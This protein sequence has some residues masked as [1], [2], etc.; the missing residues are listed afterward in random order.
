MSL[1]P[2]R[3]AFVLPRN[4][5]SLVRKR[6]YD[7]SGLPFQYLPVVLVREREFAGLRVR[8]LSCCPILSEKA[9]SKIEESVQHLK[10]EDKTGTEDG[11]VP[12]RIQIPS[13]AV[14]VKD[15]AETS[16]S[17]VVKKSVWVRIVDECKHYYSGFKLLFLDV[18]VSS[19]IVW[20]I[21]NGQTLS[22]RESKQLIRTTSDLF[23]LVPFSVFIIVPFMELLLPVALKLFPGMLPSTFTT[24][25][26][27][28]AKMKRSLVAKLEYAKFLQKTL[29]EM[30][31]EDNQDRS[32]KSARDFVTF[33]KKMKSQGDGVVDN[34]EILK[35]SKLFED[36][37]T[38]DNMTRSQLAAICRLL[39]LTPI[40][41]TNFLRLQLEMRLRHLLTDDKVISKEGLENLTIQE[42]QQACKERGM[43]AL[44][45]SAET[46]R[47]QLQ[48]WLDLS[49]NAQVPPSLLLLSRTL[50][51]P[52]SLEPQAKIAA[53]ISA[54]PESAISATSA[55]IGER[56]G[57][58]R[59]VDRF[60][61]I[62]E[63]QRKID[64]EEAEKVKAE[65]AAKKAAKIKLKLP[66]VEEL[67]DLLHQ[68]PIEKE[69]LDAAPILLDRAI[70][71]RDEKSLDPSDLG[72]LKTAIQNLSKSK[73]ESREIKTL[74]KELVDYEEDLKDLDVLKVSKK[75]ASSLNESKGAKRLFQKVNQMLG[76]VDTLV[77]SLEQKE[78]EITE[79]KAMEGR[80]EEELSRDDEN[81]VTVQELI[82]AV[83]K[84]QRS[85]DS[86]KLEQIS[87]VLSAMDVDSDGMIKVDH[88]QKV[89]ELL[90][91][92]HVQLP[93]KQIR[94]IVDMLTKEEM[95][96]I[97]QN[98]E[99][100]LSKDTKKEEQIII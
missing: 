55:Q 57:K 23:R 29:D 93:S 73:M 58:I 64:E 18:R 87:E 68:T 14:Q 51:L 67:R 30:A 15:A 24:K 61:Q 94:Q 2:R 39:E 43:R 77:A 82:D 1:I 97:E 32:S 10:K 37:I 53:T 90:G 63:E 52:D 4:C 42:L 26:E 48:Q 84:L 76:K 60:E 19:K 21:L 81:L 47:K 11:Q 5:S 3:V 22:R 75:Q 45:L 9:S 36:S 38:L 13:V 74:K 72:D 25:S 56:E 79:M 71:F 28:E 92:E 12:E 41:T 89:L 7:S 16:A 85:P 98:I 33:L 86:S 100:L 34:K 91:S 69:F 65:N 66:P 40:G 50:Y 95:L 59:N 70:P 46:L 80:T 20:K 54:L 49:L 44:G 83:R 96:E 31:P 88:V 99:G 35:F 78:K 27:R 62:K 6:Y 8:C 17:V